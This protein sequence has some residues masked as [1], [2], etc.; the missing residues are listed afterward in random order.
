MAEKDKNFSRRDFLKTSGIATGALIG[1]G[2]IGGLIGANTNKQ[3]NATDSSSSSGGTK[4]A[5]SSIR[6][7]TFF[8]SM[9]DF[10]VLS[11]ATERIFPE[12]DLGPGAIGLAV[13]Y[14]IDN[15][16]AGSYGE[17]SKEY[18]QAPFAQ[19]EPTQGYQ[20]RLKRNEMFIQGIQLM[21]EEAD[22]RF[23][24]KFVDLEGEQMDEIL[25]AFQENEIKMRGVESQFFFRLLR[26]A[27]LE[28]A[29]ADPIYGGNANMDGWQ[30][31][32][33]PGHQLAYIKDIESEDFVEIKPKSL[34]MNH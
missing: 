19:G 20:S 26:Q 30:M 6:G 21:Q 33:F 8:K 29:Y 3:D 2:I 7:L 15:Q 18:M 13:P 1:G 24:T 22:S 16:L 12:D 9:A 10:E 14:F 27:T 4:E 23:K 5:S 31:K 34:G 28:G 32:G 17:N 11:Q 25:T